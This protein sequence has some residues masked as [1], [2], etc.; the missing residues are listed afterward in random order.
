MISATAT[1]VEEH[2][3]P[4]IN[5][6]NRKQIEESIAKFSS[7][8]PVAIEDRLQSLEREWDIERT[9]QTNFAIVSLVG[10]ALGAFYDKRWLALTSGAAAFMVQH[11]LQGWCPP[12][13]ALRRLGVR[14]AREIE[15]EVFALKALRGDFQNGGNT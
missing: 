1:R 9:L 6:K 4:P 8:D 11:S 10:L 14:S 7:G 15:D 3:A 13:A 5:R 12:L 2:T